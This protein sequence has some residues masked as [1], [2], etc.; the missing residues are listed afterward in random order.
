MKHPLV[1]HIKT[2]TSLAAIILGNQYTIT[3]DN[4]SFTQVYDAIQNRESHERIAD[5]FNQANAIAR[6]L[7][8]GINPTGETVTVVD[9][10]SG[11]LFFNGEEI[12]N[13]VVDRILEFIAQGLSAEPL[14][15]FL[16]R[17]RKNSSKRSIDELYRFCEHKS[18]P[19]TPEG[20]LLAY[21]GVNDDYTDCHTRTF[22][23]RPGSVHS[24]KRND[25]DDDARQAC[26]NGFHVGS[27]EYATDF[28]SRTVIVEVDP[29]D[30]V[31][32][33]FDCDG[34]KMR[35]SKYKVVCDYK[36]P[37]PGTLANAHRPY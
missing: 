32:V 10:H 11:Q 16:A 14:I 23:N 29:A 37:L 34:Q 17:L 15:N 13:H 3:S 25:V 1:P 31:S 19:I 21:K 8:S 28:G 9:V 30:V 20:K 36:G 12:H 6:Y 26:S 4:P 27:L 18:L 24:M 7:Q 22:N 2:D 5:L 33:P 35:V